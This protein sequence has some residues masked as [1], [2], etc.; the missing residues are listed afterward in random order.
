MNI[1]E[2]GLVEFLRNVPDTERIKKGDI[3][4]KY[5][6]EGNI[7]SARAI[8]GYIGSPDEDMIFF[9]GNRNIDSKIFMIHTP[10][11][12]AIVDSTNSPLD[13]YI[14]FRRDPNSNP[15]SSFL[16]CMD[17]ILNRYMGIDVIYAKK[18][19]GGDI[20]KPENVE[21]HQN[22]TLFRTAHLMLTEMAIADTL[23]TDKPN[24]N[25]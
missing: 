10:F 4:I 18:I 22:L 9:A 14:F 17:R 11:S 7:D 15:E 1:H 12:V 21:Y 3:P 19:R 24:F 23:K 2:E 6:I 5:Y 16:F 13:K 25:C 20:Y 8:N